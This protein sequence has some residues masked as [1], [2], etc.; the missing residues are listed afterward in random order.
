MRIVTLL[1]NT[2]AVPGMEIRHGLSLYVETK[3]HK[4][5]FDM[6]PDDAFLRNA[7]ALGV[8][9]GA[10][11]VATI[12]HGH[13]DHGGGLATFLA[14]N[15]H[16]KVYIRRDAF[17]KYHAKRG[18]SALMEYIGLDSALSGHERIVL[19]EEQ[20]RIDEELLLY[21]GVSGDLYRPT[22]N[23][24]LLMEQEGQCVPDVF[25]HEQNLIITSEGH[26]VLFGGC[27]H[28]GIL[29][30]LE[31]ADAH[32]DRIDAVIAGFHLHNPMTGDWEADDVLSAIA[33]R[34]AMRHTKYYTCHCTGDAPYAY[35]KAR[36][37]EQ[38]ERIGTGSMFEA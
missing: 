27:S 35:L 24:S 6:G 8:D 2:A 29:N 22:A 38:I 33:N 17:A 10:V 16:A 4:L 31:G 15:D 26:A 18:D 19:T 3:K 21:S 7:K 25:S 9:I 20:L 32:V 14:H 11:D 13:S 28:C 34:L 12:S 5:L 30:I 1:E 36:L 37:G 23:A